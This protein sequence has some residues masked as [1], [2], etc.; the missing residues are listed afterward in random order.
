[1]NFKKLKPATQAAM[2]KGLAKLH[3]LQSQDI[4]NVPAMSTSMKAALGKTRQPRRAR[5]IKR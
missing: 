1:M 3:G 2:R 4:L 5:S